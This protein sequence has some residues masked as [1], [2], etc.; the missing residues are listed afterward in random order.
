[1]E[2]RWG[3]RSNLGVQVR[4][5]ASSWRAPRG[6]HLRDISASGAFLEME[7]SLPPLKRIEVE[8]TVRKADH[9]DLIRIPA[10]VVRK[11]DRGVGVEWHETPAYPIEQLVANATDSIEAPPFPSR[12]TASLI[13]AT[14]SFIA[15]G[16]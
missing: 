9:I 2:H 1:M 6:A 13:A 3:Q 12:S 16:H 10:S 11:A 5:H 8:I 4:L 14:P 15:V 7:P